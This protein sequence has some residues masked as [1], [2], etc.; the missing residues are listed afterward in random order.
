M[1]A[2][3]GSYKRVGSATVVTDTGE[4]KKIWKRTP[5]KAETIINLRAG[6]IGPIDLAEA[7]TGVCLR[8]CIR[9]VADYY[10]ITLGKGP[11]GGSHRLGSSPGSGPPARLC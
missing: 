5:M 11:G 10:L 4:P 1:I 2:D 8:G 9:R 3:W 7:H 6:A